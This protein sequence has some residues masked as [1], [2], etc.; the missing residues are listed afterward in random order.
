MLFCFCFKKDLEVFFLFNSLLKV[1]DY[2][3]SKD[4]SVW[5]I[6][7]SLV[8]IS[9]VQVI[10]KRI[11]ETHK[12]PSINLLEMGKCGVVTMDL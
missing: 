11:E 9:K 4:L 7:R 2:Q 1:F 8:T 5:G 3:G 10:T 6:V 12:V